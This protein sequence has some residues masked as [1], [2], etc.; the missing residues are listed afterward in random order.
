MSVE[1]SRARVFAGNHLVTYFYGAQRAPQ[2][3]NTSDVILAST[4]GK[5]KN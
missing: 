4:N 5:E 3:G 1:L 2:Y